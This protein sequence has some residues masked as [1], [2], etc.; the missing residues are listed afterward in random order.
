LPAQERAIVYIGLGDNDSAFYWLEKSYEEHFGSIISL[1][2]DP[3]FD[4][5][6]SDP[7][8]PVLARKIN[9]IP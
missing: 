5:I 7:R 6:K 2:A 4:S 8:F 3:F 1:T 9:L